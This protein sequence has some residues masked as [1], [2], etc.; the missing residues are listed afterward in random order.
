MTMLTT[1]KRRRA[2]VNLRL[3]KFLQCYLRSSCDIGNIMADSAIC[4]NGSGEGR[5]GGWSA[6]KV[7]LAA[8]VAVC[9]KRALHRA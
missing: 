8:P 1:V 6:S 2:A 3:H 4:H 5:E 7:Q 9:E